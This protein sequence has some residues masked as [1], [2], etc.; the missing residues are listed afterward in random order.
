MDKSNVAKLTVGD[1]VTYKIGQR[2]GKPTAAVVVRNTRKGLTVYR[3]NHQQ[4]V[5]I[6]PEDIIGLVSNQT[7]AKAKR[8]K[9]LETA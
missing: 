1:E 8:E 3:P 5:Q 6:K 7:K 2:R 4:L 9:T